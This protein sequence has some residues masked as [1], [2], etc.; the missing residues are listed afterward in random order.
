MRFLRESGPCDDSVKFFAADLREGPLIGFWNSAFGVY[1][2]SHVEGRHRV[3]N[4][5]RKMALQHRLDSARL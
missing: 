1:V 5:R 2:S 3:G 4:V